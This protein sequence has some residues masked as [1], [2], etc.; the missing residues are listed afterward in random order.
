MTPAAFAIALKM[1]GLA[2]ARG[3]IVDVSGRCPGGAWKFVTV[4]G[5][6]DRARTLRKVIWQ[7]RE[8]IRRR[9]AASCA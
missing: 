5:K 1:R 9:D 4:N 8:E 3:R 6:V 2:V 7:R